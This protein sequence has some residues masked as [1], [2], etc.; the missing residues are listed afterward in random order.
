MTVFA[1]IAASPNAPALERAITERFPSGS[2]YV[3]APGQYLVDAPGIT[4]RQLSES[5]GIANGSLAQRILVLPVT[6]YDGWHNRDLWE[7]LSSHLDSSRPI[8]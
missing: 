8:V 5:L 7:W 2:R 1:I 3:I 4:S 6:G